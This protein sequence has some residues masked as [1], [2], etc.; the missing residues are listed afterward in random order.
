MKIPRTL[1]LIALALAS[2]AWAK[3]AV[4]APATSPACVQKP[5][6]RNLMT[7]N[8]YI[9][10]GLDKLSQ[11]QLA[12]LNAWLVR[13]TRSICGPSTHKTNTN[14]NTNS[15]SVPAPQAKQNN[16]SFGMTEQHVNTTKRIVS[17]IDGVFHGW[18][19]NTRFKLTNGQ[20]W[21]QA[22]PGYYETTMKSPKVT[23]KK[24]LIGYILQVR[25]KEV[26]VR[27]VR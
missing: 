8:E 18:T 23:I 25:G 17:H 27:R 20:V 26:F 3:P 6:I 12:N 15:A 21:V 2:S 22:G 13:Y 9:K 10:T 11:K 24:L 19:G 16:A 14:A 5:D 7:V 4:P 1:P